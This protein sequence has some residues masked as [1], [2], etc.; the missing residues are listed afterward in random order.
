MVII[1]S[2]RQKLPGYLNILFKK[3]FMDVTIQDIHEELLELL[4]RFHAICVENEINYSVHGGTMLGA[5]R[6]HGFIAWD[7][8]AD[9]SFTRSE[10]EKFRAVIDTYVNDEIKYDENSRYP[11][12]VLKRENR[13]VVWAD[14]F[15]YDYISS[16]KF[17]Q[18][19]KL[20]GTDYYILLTRSKEEQSMSNKKGLYK[21]LKKLIM[22]LM[23]NIANISLLS[24]RLRRANRFMTRYQG[25][26]EYIHR[27]NDTHVGM[28]LILPAYV[29]TK[30]ELKSFD[31]TELMIS[32]YYDDILRS[33][34]G[35]DYMTPR[36]T[37]GDEIHIESYNSEKAYF[38]DMYKV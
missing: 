2:C 29:M 10:Y 24:K 19:I 28:K 13:P 32:S 37:N 33:S 23:V 9:L 8:D 3:V 12:I 18:K 20:T 27:S 17:I 38:E 31:N 35:T 25:S 34:Y 5:V 4:K 36:R 22:N 15:I 30:Y 14:I 16:K 7:D 21:G 6:E 1:C 26:K 11:K